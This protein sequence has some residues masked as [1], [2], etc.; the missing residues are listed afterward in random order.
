MGWY[1][2]GMIR[3]VMWLF[4]QTLGFYED[5]HKTWNWFKDYGLEKDESY[6]DA[7][8]E[9]S[10]LCQFYSSVGVVIGYRLG[11]WGLI[12]NMVRRIFSTTLHPDWLWGQ[13][14]GY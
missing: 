11:G 6:N 1:W 10:N 3:N 5:D 9:V 12:L 14:S 7:E 2:E 4:S 8:E 13:S